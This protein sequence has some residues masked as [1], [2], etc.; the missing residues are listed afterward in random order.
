MATG[1]KIPMEIIDGFVT[2]MKL[3]NAKYAFMSTLLGLKILI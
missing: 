2:R 3:P 1:K